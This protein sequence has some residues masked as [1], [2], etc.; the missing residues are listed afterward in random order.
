M[1]LTALITLIW[2][3]NLTLE[4]YSRVFKLLDKYSRSEH[5]NFLAEFFHR[6]RRMNTIC[7]FV[8]WMPSLVH[9]VRRAF[10]FGLRL[11]N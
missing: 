1:T 2:A 5:R 10:M 4:E 6:N 11:R 8:P 9:P 3:M 7:A